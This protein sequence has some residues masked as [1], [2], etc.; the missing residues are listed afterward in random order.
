MKRNIV[1]LTIPAFLCAV[2]LLAPDAPAQVTVRGVVCPEDPIP[3]G[4]IK[5]DEDTGTTDCGGEVWVIEP[6]TNKAPGSAMVVC[7]DQPEPPG[8]ETLHYTSSSGQCGG[9]GAGNT[10]AIRKVG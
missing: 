1:R 9:T 3:E 7:A 5:V 4:W 2:F 8:W 6:Y 10:K